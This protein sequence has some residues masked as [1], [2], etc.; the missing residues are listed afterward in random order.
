MDAHPAI[1]S[2]VK[3]SADTIERLRQ[4]CGLCLNLLLLISRQGHIELHAN[5]SRRLVETTPQPL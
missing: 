2:P 3:P 1:G 4:D 5:P